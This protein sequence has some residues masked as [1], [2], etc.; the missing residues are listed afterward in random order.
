MYII[1]CLDMKGLSALCGVADAAFHI[2][3]VYILTIGD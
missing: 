2:Q 3:G 1:I